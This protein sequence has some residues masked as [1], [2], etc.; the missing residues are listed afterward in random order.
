MRAMW[1]LT[2]LMVVAGCSRK[3]E[4]Q[5]APEAASGPAVTITNIATQAMNVYMNTGG[6]DVLLGTVKPNSTQT[7]PVQV[8]PGTRVTLRARTA[9]GT[10]TY[11]R[12]NVMMT[13]PF[14]WTVP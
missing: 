13:G 4:V 11:S 9:D 6:D 2:C 1:M 3:V 7:I 12:D 5:T 14:A 10:R 8:Q